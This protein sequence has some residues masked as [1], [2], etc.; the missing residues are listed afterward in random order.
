LSI[1]YGIAVVTF[2]DS[3][4]GGAVT[5][6]SKLRELRA[7]RHLS[8]RQVE[9]R[10]GPNKDTMSLIE[11]GVHQPR[12]QTLGRIAKAFDMSVAELRAELEAAE[13]PLEQAPFLQPSLLD[14]LLEEERRAEEEW[15]VL[16][17][18]EGL[19]RRGEQLE[20]DFRASAESADSIPLGDFIMF[21]QVLNALRAHFEKTG[22]RGHGAEQAREAMEH[23]D[24]VA[25]RV[26]RLVN[27]ELFERLDE[28]QRR[29]VE[30]FKKGWASP[31]GRD[32]G[33]EADHVDNRADAS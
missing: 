20:K 26:D 22:R 15:L 31:G 33:E 9:E 28:E 11:R 27:Q 18:L 16:V 5:Y 7:E 24:A 3:Y 19:I 8:L 1:L 17:L 32:A 14:E 13:H 29:E 10:G 23:L 12:V 21:G 25:S 4:S 2:S 6:A 30:T